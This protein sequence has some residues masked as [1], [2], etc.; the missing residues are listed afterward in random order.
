MIGM[1]DMEAKN[2]KILFTGLIILLTGLLIT[3]YTGQEAYVKSYPPSSYDSFGSSV[4]DWEWQEENIDKQAQ[5]VNNEDQIQ[6]IYEVTE[7]PAQ[8]RNPMYKPSENYLEE[9]WKMY[10]NSYE[11]ARENNWFNYTEGLEDGY[12]NNLSETTHY[13]HPENTNNEENLNPE[14]PEYLMYDLNPETGDHRLIGFMYQAN[15]FQQRGEQFAGPLSLWHYHL[16]IRETCH[17][18]NHPIVGK[19]SWQCDDEDRSV[20]SPEMIHVWFVE[21][22]EGP[23]ATSMALDPEKIDKPEKKNREEFFQWL[24]QSRTDDV[25]EVG[26][27][28]RLSYQI[29]A[30]LFKRI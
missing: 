22:Q 9:A 12:N 5:Q 4:I 23:F 13:H 10:N 25:E 14:S 3:T 11:A 17:E 18:N 7:Y 24:K 26:I 20:R 19:L 8:S 28:D 29:K 6:I 15:D 16:Y 21:H 30:I 1:I 2:K 27:W